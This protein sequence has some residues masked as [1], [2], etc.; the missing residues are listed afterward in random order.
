MPIAFTNETVTWA[1]HVQG[2][3]SE[4]GEPDEDGKFEPQVVEA[5][6]TWPGCGAVFRARCL[7]G[8]TRE[9]IHNFAIVHLHRDPL[10][11]VKKKVGVK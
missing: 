7:T 10:A 8:R 3:W 2:R 9:H 1:P 11:T 5:L 6:C 4:R